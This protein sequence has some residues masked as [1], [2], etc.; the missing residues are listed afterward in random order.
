MTSTT[1]FGFYLNGLPGQTVV[2]EASTNLITWTAVKTNSLLTGYYYFSD[3]AWTN[4]PCRF[5]RSRL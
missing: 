3:L 2:L 1:G 5:Y 4:F